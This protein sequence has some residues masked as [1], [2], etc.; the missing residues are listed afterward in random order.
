MVMV[1]EQAATA[2]TAQRIV[3]AGLTIAAHFQNQGYAA[4]MVVDG[5]VATRAELIGLDAFR[6]LAA[7]Q[8]I[9]T[10]LFGTGDDYT[11]HQPDGTLNKLDTHLFCNRE[12][13]KRQIYPAI[14]PLQSGSRLLNE[15]PVSPEHK[16]VA[17]QTRQLLQRYYKLRETVEA[18]GESGLTEDDRQAFRRGQRIE[19]F[20]TQP[21]VVAEPY[22]DIPGEYVSL[23]DTIKGFEALLSGQYDSVPERNFWMV[24]TIEQALAK[25]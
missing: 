6:R 18:Q 1:F 11:C 17:Q 24:G 3:Q 16:R 12:L 8:A 13:F 19:Q 5:Q 10:I 2:E 4:L 25:P 23:A 20:L 14:D 7:Q 9:T 21:F 15:G 22:T